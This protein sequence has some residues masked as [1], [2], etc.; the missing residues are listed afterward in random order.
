MPRLTKQQL[1]EKYRKIYEQRRGGFYHSSDTRDELKVALKDFFG[2]KDDMFMTL[3]MTTG[4]FNVY[5]QREFLDTLNLW[6]QTQVKL[7]DCNY[8]EHDQD[9]YEFC[10]F[11]VQ[12]KSDELL[13]KCPIC[14]LGIALG[15]MVSGYTFITK[16]KEMFEFCKN[17][18]GQ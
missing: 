12:P 16:N 18:I 11:V 8:R 7:L 10:S 5:T 9:G 4:I 15:M 2:A 6:K 3:H 17:Y 1:M 13:E 14:P